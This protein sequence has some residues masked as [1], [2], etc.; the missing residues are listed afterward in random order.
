[1]CESLRALREA[2]ALIRTIAAQT[3]LL[4]G[5]VWAV[6]VAAAGLKGARAGLST[7]LTAGTQGAVAYYATYVVGRSAERY[8]A[9]RKSWGP[10]GPRRVVERI[11]DEVDRDSLLRQARADIRARLRGAA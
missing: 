5:T 6:S 9:Q 10:G 11:L 4:M 3:D 2:G 8:F 1:M 7:A